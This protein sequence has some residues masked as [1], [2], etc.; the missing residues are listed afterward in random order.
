MNRCRK[1]FADG[2]L[3]MRRD[4]PLY[5]GA[6]SEGSAPGAWIAGSNQTGRNA[7]TGTLFSGNAP[8][9]RNHMLRLTALNKIF[10]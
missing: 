7:R 3:D 8:G 9:G 4:T 1:W 10:N 6:S 5:P 2:I